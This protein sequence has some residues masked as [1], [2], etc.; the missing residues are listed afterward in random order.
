MT[1]AKTTLFPFTKGAGIPIARLAPEGVAA[2]HI[3]AVIALVW[4]Y[5]SSTR[6][7]SLLLAEPD[8]RLRKRN[9][10]V[11]ATFHGHAAQEVARTRAG[12]G[13]LVHL[14]L[15]GAEW[16]QAGETISTPGKNIAWDLVYETR[17]ILSIHRGAEELASI[18]VDRPVNHARLSN[19]IGHHHF[20][21][22]LTNGEN[23]I[24]SWPSPAFTRGKRLSSS[25]F[26]E[27]SLDQFADDNGF[28]L[29]KGRKRTKFGRMSDSWK[30]L[31]KSPSPE[32]EQVEP[33]LQGDIVERGSPSQ[34]EIVGTAT[35]TAL[36]SR[37]ANVLWQPSP[38]RERLVGKSQ[39]PPP[40]AIQ[41]IKPLTIDLDRAQ[42][43]DEAEAVGEITTPRLGPLQSEGLPLISPPIKR[44]GIAVSYFQDD[45]VTRSE[46][47]SSADEL[48]RAS[49]ERDLLP[50]SGLDLVADELMPQHGNAGHQEHEQQDGRQEE[51]IFTA[52]SQDVGELQMGVED[53]IGPE[54][55]KANAIEDSLAESQV[56]NTTN[57]V[58]TLEPGFEFLNTSP[59]EQ[60]PSSTFDWPGTAT[61]E[62]PM[63]DPYANLHEPSANDSRRERV[64]GPQAGPV[65]PLLEMA[66]S[67]LQFEDDEEPQA[68]EDVEHERPRSRDWPSKLEISAQECKFD[69]AYPAPPFPFRQS[70]H[71]S[72][73]S[74]EG[75]RR[76]SYLDGTNDEVFL[77]E[78]GE[79]RHVNKD[80][81]PELVETSR[82]SDENSVIA[83]SSDEEEPA[84]SSTGRR[85]RKVSALKKQR[86][87]AQNIRGDA[88]AQAPS[89]SG[90]DPSSAEIIHDQATFDIEQPA[91]ESLSLIQQPV[92]V[93]GQEE[94]LAKEQVAE[95]AE[96]AGQ[97]E[98]EVREQEAVQINNTVDQRTVVQMLTPENT[99]RDLIVDQAQ[100]QDR[101]V[102]SQE[103]VLPPTPENTQEPASQ[104]QDS[105]E[106][107]KAHAPVSTPIGASIPQT[108]GPTSPHQRR[109][110]SR[111]S[112]RFQGSAI[113]EVVSPYFTPRRKS[114]IHEQEVAAAPESAAA[115]SE[116]GLTN[117]F[118]T[119]TSY[120]APLTLIQD[121]FFQAVDVLAVCTVA[122]TEPQR[123]RAGPKD[124]HTTLHLADSSLKESVTAQIFRPSKFA[125]PRAERGDVVL[126]RNMKVQS[127]KRK[128]M[129]LS[130][131]SSAWAVFAAH[132]ADGV[133]L[134]RAVVAGP[135]V[136][137]GKQEEEHGVSIRK[138]WLDTGSAK[139]PLT[140]QTKN[141]GISDGPVTNG[142][143]D[144]N[145]HVEVVVDNSDT[146]LRH[147]LRD[148]T[149]YQDKVVAKKPSLEQV[150]WS[151]GP[152]LDLSPPDKAKAAPNEGDE[153]MYGVSDDEDAENVPPVPSPV[154]NMRSRR[155]GREQKVVHELRDGAKYTDD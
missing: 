153:D 57:S 46:L 1:S 92:P 137:Y 147:E 48:T 23:G 67:G 84:W 7:L 112:S 117:G 133:E 45:S 69:A 30:L 61:A 150:R 152:Q 27:A 149:V 16:V 38:R 56:V 115:E 124:F 99:Q 19:E 14:A 26:F 90:E 145:G 143:T 73:S 110:S 25:S 66:R 80:T 82:R 146:A 87:F 9:G 155:T 59:L 28:I 81:K 10:Q 98:E 6:T 88:P 116:S 120:Y 35:P 3:E 29:G 129:L 119:S 40:H 62:D 12:I 113:T 125:L 65:D 2:G 18:D 15:E 60:Q 52:A 111:L 76:S 78:A 4:P 139:H 94:L 121:H 32:K 37:E 148:G 51:G 43:S 91:S 79:D 20:G 103:D 74:R 107:G 5:S 64:T 96:P 114:Q 135:P 134:L 86:E 11:K 54:L 83:I 127:R 36:T 41:R 17:A 95:D 101:N 44:T 140:N 34:H 151:F 108:D 58:P 104:I 100:Y 123:A 8:I 131:D 75:S 21:G 105:G 63:S 39:M 24:S 13:D 142:H 130:I 144:A 47:D 93:L 55:E 141:S 71:R 128:C 109:K 126:L 53:S 118:T 85:L 50:E 138:W 154:H 68:L 106:D 42:D 97:H 22:T 122:S 136:E 31:D 102:Q 33:S 49:Y 70:W 77:E 132:G 72:S 89:K